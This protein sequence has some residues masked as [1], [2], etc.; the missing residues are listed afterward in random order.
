MGAIIDILHLGENELCLIKAE[1]PYC[2]V[3]NQTNSHH[4]IQK[5]RIIIP[6]EVEDSYYLFLLDNCIAMS[7]ANFLCRVDSDRKF[8]ERM[9]ARIEEAIENFRFLGGRKS[10]Y[11]DDLM[12]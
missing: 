9:R 5:Y 12:P 4:I 7:S 2:Q 10:F 8:A 3:T 6:D 1:Y 11:L